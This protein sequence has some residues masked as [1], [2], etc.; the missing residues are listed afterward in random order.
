M[1]HDPQ[2]RDNP[3]APTTAPRARARSTIS[4]ASTTRAT[5]TCRPSWS[6][7]APC[8][9]IMTAASPSPRS[10]ARRGSAT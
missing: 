8:S 10:A 6:A 3:P 4:S 5:T 9:T 2:L 7:S 1:M